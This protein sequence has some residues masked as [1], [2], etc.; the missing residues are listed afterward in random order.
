M[1]VDIIIL[2]GRGSKGDPGDL[3]NCFPLLISIYIWMCS[4][5]PLEDSNAKLKHTQI[6]FQFRNLLKSF[7]NET[8]MSGGIKL[9]ALKFSKLHIITVFLKK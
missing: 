4:K 7:Y 3:R 9:S 5:K 1:F 6:R 8:K 2:F